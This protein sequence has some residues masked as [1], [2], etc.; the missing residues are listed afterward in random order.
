MALLTWCHTASTLRSPRRPTGLPRAQ[1]LPD[2]RGCNAGRAAAATCSTSGRRAVGATSS[3]VWRT[4]PA[5]ALDGGQEVRDASTVGSPATWIRS[6]V[7][8][9]AARSLP[10]RAAAV[11][12]AESSGC[13]ATWRTGS[14]VVDAKFVTATTWQAYVAIEWERDRLSEIQIVCGMRRDAADT[15]SAT[16]KSLRARTVPKS[17]PRRNRTLL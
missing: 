7:S 5:C 6:T 15:L 3:I 13:G 1:R 12:A 8:A 17:D 10:Q 2:D 14:D 16:A 4:R 11:A 9:P